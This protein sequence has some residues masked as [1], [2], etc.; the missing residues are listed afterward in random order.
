MPAVVLPD[1]DVEKVRR[2]CD[3][4]VP[5]RV[6]DKV[7]L[8]VTTKGKFV[9][10]HERRP[11]WMGVG[12]WTSSAIARF[13]YD[14]EGLWTLYFGDRYGGWTLYFDLDTRQPVDVLINELKEDPTCVFWG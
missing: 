11:P 4:H 3:E 13:R 6:R 1:I 12:E 2:F 10:I 9:D 5:P 14:G 8:E 7:R